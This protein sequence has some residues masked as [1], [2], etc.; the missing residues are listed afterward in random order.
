MDTF[1]SL[2]I[3][4]SDIRN[5]YYVVVNDNDLEPLELE[6]LD[7]EDNCEDIQ[8]KELEPYDT[9]AVKGDDLFLQELKEPLDIPLC[10]LL[11]T[12]EPLDIISNCS[13]FNKLQ[14]VIAWCKRF[15]ENAR[16]P[17]S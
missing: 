2:R 17:M 5:E 8:Y 14:R 4:L 11:K 12:F 16:H 15:I 13:S 6:I 10:A 3:K 7:L 1:K 9:T